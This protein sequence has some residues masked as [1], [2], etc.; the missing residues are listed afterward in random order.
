V[1]LNFNVFPFFLRNFWKCTSKLKFKN[2]NNNEMEDLI[3]L[4]E[5]FE[6]AVIVLLISLVLKLNP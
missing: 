2:K 1:S 5:I 6:Q 3:L 4:T